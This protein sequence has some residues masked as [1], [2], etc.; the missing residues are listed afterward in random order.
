MTKRS[1]STIMSW[2]QLNIHPDD[3]VILFV[4]RLSFHA[5]AHPLVMYQALERAATATGRQ[6][7]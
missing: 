3:I 4:G 2:Q 7:V 5:K 6:L 1:K